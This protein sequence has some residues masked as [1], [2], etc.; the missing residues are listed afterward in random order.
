MRG[1]PLFPFAITAIL[2]IGLITILSFVG[3]YQGGDVAQENGEEQFET[4]YELGEHVYI[5]NC[6]G[7]HGGDLG[8]VGSNPALNALEGNYSEDEI[9]TI[10]TEGRGAMPA[11]GR[12][13]NEEVDAVIEFLL[14]ESE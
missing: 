9:A 12:L 10:I 5:G 1:K 3:L 6:S 14:T 8:G 7:C 11:F 2:G 13:S 4:S